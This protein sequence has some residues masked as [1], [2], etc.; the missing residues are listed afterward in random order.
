MGS[1]KG[2]IERDN[3]YLGA[4]WSYS[5]V[6]FSPDGRTAAYGSSREEPVE[7]DVFYGASHACEGVPMRGDLRPIHQNGGSDVI[8]FGTGGKSVFVASD[9]GITE[10]SIETGKPLRVITAD[11]KS[12]RAS[13]DGRYIVTTFDPQGRFAAGPTTVIGGDHPEGFGVVGGG[14]TAVLQIIPT[15]DP[16]SRRTVS[17]RGFGE[18]PLVTP[19][20]NGAYLIHGRYRGVGYQPYDGGERLVFDTGHVSVE[21]ESKDGSLVAF[22]SPGGPAHEE[23]FVPHDRPTTIEVWDVRGRTKIY[24]IEGDGEHQEAFF[25]GDPP[26]LVILLR[27]LATQPKWF[28][29]TARLYDGRTG[30]FERE[31]SIAPTAAFSAPTIPD[32]E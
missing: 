5:T 21:S 6:C 29:E 15:A 17:V 14:G 25:V 9:R 28:E 31:V 30:V 3:V 22:G 26:T 2:L 24:S 18:M 16:D 10:I 8:G 1:R 27:D 4:L 23:W 20:L 32:N 7:W 13:P 12:P 11:L 19:G